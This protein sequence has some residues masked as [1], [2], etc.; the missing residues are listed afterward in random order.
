MGIEGRL[1]I[2]F[3]V[4]GGKVLGVGI[5][6]SRPLR[7][8]S[9]FAGKTPENVLALI[10]TLYSICGT[11][12][13]CAAVGAF[14]HAL[15]L[16]VSPSIRAAR[17]I[18]VWAE[19][20]REHLLRLVM[21]I[22]R[23]SERFGIGDIMPMT[24]QMKAALDSVFKLGADGDC[25]GDLAEHIDRLDDYLARAVYGEPLGTWRARQGSAALAPWIAAQ[26]TDVAA[27]LGQIDQKEWWRIGGAGAL[28]GL[29][30]LKGAD[31]VNAMK[32]DDFIA[33]PTWQGHSYETTPL[34]RQAQESVIRDLM[35]Q[36]GTGLMTR[37]IA[38]LVELAKIP[39]HMRQLLD[40]SK[41]ETIGGLNK[42]IATAVEKGIG[43]AQVEAARGRLAHA[44]WMD[45]GKVDQYRILAPT[46]WNFH[47]QGIA[48][49]ALK[50][51]S[52]ADGDVTD[53]KAQADAVISAI[54]PCVAY[55]VRIT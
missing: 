38:L 14:E 20:A 19:T 27:L 26:S 5:A 8:T 4:E 49:K 37:L 22:G 32:T 25:A 13:T 10:P 7:I 52:F 1:D 28:D 3:E 23:P 40:A 51:L 46:E 11:A 48:A 30:L 39:D 33:F 41:S 12:Q 55:E 29:P 44:V 53:L 16:H 6:S 9:L 21:M 45:K 35:A 31:L 15:G 50:A 47:P 54:D 18:A 17:E 36:S 43:L 34:A 42:D 24:Q 2:S